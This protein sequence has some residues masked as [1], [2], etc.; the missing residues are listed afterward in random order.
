MYL[1]QP[2]ARSCGSGHFFLSK[3]NT[4]TST[5]PSPNDNYPILTKYSTF[6]PIISSS[7]EAELESIKH[8]GKDDMHIQV[9]PEKLGHKQGTMLI[10]TDNNTASSFLIS[11][12]GKYRFKAWDMN[13]H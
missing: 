1:V 6:K 12:I 7:A 11:I 4:T 9:I 3:K 2:T 8:N 5:K 10:K 13:F